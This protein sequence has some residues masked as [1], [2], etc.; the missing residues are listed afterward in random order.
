MPPDTSHWEKR[1]KIEK[2]KGWKIKNGGK[3]REES[4]KTRRELFWFV[5][6]FVFVFA[7]HFSKPLKFVLGLPK[8]EFSPAKTHFMPGGGDRKN[9]FAP[10]EK[11]FLLQMPLPVMLLMVVTSMHSRKQHTRS[12][13]NHK[14][15]KTRGFVVHFHVL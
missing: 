9:D 15:D 3:W 1:R 8:W 5:F 13:I 4:N 11:I 10:S 6:V 7:F 14:V 2:G 12:T